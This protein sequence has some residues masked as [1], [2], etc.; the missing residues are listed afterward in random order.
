[1]AVHY[2]EKINRKREH[3]DGEN[4]NYYFALI[5]TKLGSLELNDGNY[6][7]ALKNFDR[8]LDYFKDFKNKDNI[9]SH[10]TADVTNKMLFDILHSIA[11]C[12]LEEN[13]VDKANDFCETVKNSTLIFL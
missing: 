3:W 10:L 5:M 9:S 11:T 4:K 12:C 13:G 6:T 8:A 7:L 2:I 1:M